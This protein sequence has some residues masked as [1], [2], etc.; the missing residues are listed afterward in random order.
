MRYAAAMLVWL[1]LTGPAAAQYQLGDGRALDNNLRQG[2]GGVNRQGATGR[3]GAHADA[4]VTGNVPGLAGFRG[5]IGYRAAG[6][7]SGDLGS[8][9]LDR[10]RTISYPNQTQVPDYGVGPYNGQPDRS[11]QPIIY[12]SGAVVSAGDVTSG[13]GTSGA[14]VNT[15]DTNTSLQVHR[16]PLEARIEADARSRTRRRMGLAQNAEGRLLE[17]TASPLLGMQ[18]REVRSPTPGLTEPLRPYAVPEAEAGTEEDADRAERDHPLAVPL[19]DDSDETDDDD[20]A[21]L[22]RFR[23]GPMRG[24][25]PNAAKLLADRLEGRLDTTR[26]TRLRADLAERIAAIDE[27]MSQHRQGSRQAAPGQD[28]YLDL[29]GQI[30]RREH[31]P[32]DQL[33]VPADEREGAAAEAEDQE[34]DGQPL[35][36]LEAEAKRAAALLA[37]AQDKANAYRQKL[38]TEEETAESELERFAPDAETTDALVE[39]II[40]RLD[41]SVAP[42]SSFTRERESRLSQVM[43]KAEQYMSD[44]RYLD[45]EHAYQLAL[46]LQP[47]HPLALV[48]RM[49]AQLGAGMSMSTS[50]HLRTLLQNHPELI[51]ARYAP[52]VLPDTQRLIELKDKYRTQTERYDQPEPALLLAY[53]AYQQGDQVVLR[54]ALDQWSERSRRDA[55]LPLVRRIWVDKDSASPPDQ[56]GPTSP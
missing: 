42:L 21:A 7:F 23:R 1:A 50:Y 14:P 49:H 9:E 11:R 44:G 3:P 41:Y 56:E 30:S 18:S 24:R 16:Q 37:E 2:S 54:E 8:R 28:V 35:D 36:A 32:A 6:E 20:A 52:P 22:D 55:L 4:I 25:R 19:D 39:A 29:L 33:T 15:L 47:G 10:F 43:A 40:D 34:E 5:N 38:A 27:V 17:V 51:A 13:R 45:A 46:G 53:I 48:G 26:S 31:V 12:G